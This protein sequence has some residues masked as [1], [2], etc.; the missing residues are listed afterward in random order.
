MYRGVILSQIVSL[1]GGSLIGVSHGPID[2]NVK[3][4]ALHGW[5]RT[6]EDFKSLLVRPGTLCLDLPGFGSSPEPT[7]AWGAAGY[8]DQ[9]ATALKPIVERTGPVI[10]VG[11]SFGGRV[12]TCLAANHPRLVAGLLLIGVPL[13]RSKPHRPTLRF[14]LA[15]WLNKMGLYGND[16]ME[17]LRHRKGSADYRAA[18]GI[19]RDIFVRVVNE[20]YTDELNRIEC[21]TALLWGCNDSAAP[22]AQAEVAAKHVSNLLE[23]T[24][25]DAGHDV[26]LSN[27]DEL[28]RLISVLDQVSDR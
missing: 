26:H 14:R 17:R 18:T 4:V 8:A 7:E 25:V 6:R 27:P 19:M 5:G 28:H 2:Q 1:L 23:F 21:P 12:A 10:V 22:L 3:I 16:R 13:I 15:R 11:H 20:D 24:K 9:L